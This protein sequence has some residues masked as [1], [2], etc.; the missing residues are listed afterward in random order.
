LV[1]QY[2]S[3]LVKASG[4][5]QIDLWSVGCA[6]GEEPYSL[7]MLVD[8]LIKD[9]GV[10][11][12]YGV[13]G[14]DISMPALGKARAGIFNERRILSV[15]EAYRG[16]YFLPVEKN[17]FQITPSI[18]DRVCFSRLNM[19]KLAE[20]PMRDIDVIFCQNV[21]IYFK[22]WR[23]HDIAN[24]LSER[25]AV[26]GLLVFGVGELLDWTHPDMERVQFDD[27]LAFVRR[28]TSDASQAV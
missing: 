7:A 15:P 1:E 5:R 17:R 18:R 26:G 19:L 23:K 11:R 4:R 21:L 3:D 16:R 27:T 25:L 6:T 24:K 22:R 9:S 13:T 2:V 20:A 10:D 12:Y 8:A 28:A 14:T